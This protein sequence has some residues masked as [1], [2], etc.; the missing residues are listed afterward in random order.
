[1][2][3]NPLDILL[4]TRSWLTLGNQIQKL[5]QCYSRLSSNLV[6]LYLQGFFD[7]NGTSWILF[8]LHLFAVSQSVTLFISLFIISDAFAMLLL[9]SGMNVDSELK[10]VIRWHM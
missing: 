3:P 6:Y 7:N 8:C 9:E 4:E 1:M 10:R 2:T 5:F